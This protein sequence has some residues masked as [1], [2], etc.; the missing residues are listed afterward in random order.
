MRRLAQRNLTSVFSGIPRE[1]T[2]TVALRATKR[3]RR[4]PIWEGTYLNFPP[5]VSVGGGGGFNLFFLSKSSIGSK[6]F[7]NP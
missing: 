3:G 1:E 7:E 5:H 6:K 2:P 4:G